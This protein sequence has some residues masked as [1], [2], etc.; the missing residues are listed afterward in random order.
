MGLK[1]L[2]NFVVVEGISNDINMENNFKTIKI[3]RNIINKSIAANNECSN[4]EFTLMKFT[5]KC[6][7]DNT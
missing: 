1:M 3:Y 5:F 7:S 2:T 6:S 4:E